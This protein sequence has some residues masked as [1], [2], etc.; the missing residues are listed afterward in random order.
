L[1]PGQKIVIDGAF[2][3]NNE[4]IRNAQS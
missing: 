1:S 3:L 4:R 2:H